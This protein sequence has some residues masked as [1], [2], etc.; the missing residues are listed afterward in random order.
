MQNGA[1]SELLSHWKLENPYIIG[2]DFGGSTVLRTHLLNEVSF[3]KIILVDPVAVAPWGSTF[4]RHVKNYEDAFQGIPEYIH[5]EIV[6]T[7]VKGAMH[8]EVSVET[9]EGIKRPWLGKQGQEAFY[10]QI[11]QANQKYTDEVEPLYKS[12]N[13]PVLILWGE[14]DTW[15]PLERGQ[16]LHERV[17]TSSFVAGHLCR[18]INQQPCYL[19]Y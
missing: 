6:S 17:S 16:K 18:K 3:S 4:F 1:L 11:V 14:E 2:H 19:I 12:I 15:I 7:Y 13:V 8:K 9:L 10:R 5:E